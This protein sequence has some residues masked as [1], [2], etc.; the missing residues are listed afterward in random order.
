[1]DS[2][3]LKGKI[4]IPNVLSFYRLISFPAVLY[5]AFAEMQS[6]FVS[7]LVINLITDALDGIIARAFKLETEFGAKLDAHADIGMYITAILGIIIFKWNEIAPHYISY[8][9][10]IVAYFLP[11]VVSY[12]KFRAFPSYHLYSSKIVGYLQGIFFFT[13]FVF[14]F[15]VWFYYFVII[16]GIL[17]LIEQTLIVIISQELKTNAKGLYWVLK[18]DNIK[19]RK[20]KSI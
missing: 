4:N 11:K 6:I 7:L 13:L 17:S 20:M 10:F 5:F 12:F 9:S 14:D 2:I 19:N 3:K 8:S 1:M 18:G 15:Y 16:F